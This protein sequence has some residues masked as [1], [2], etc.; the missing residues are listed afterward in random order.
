MKGPA[1]IARELPSLPLAVA[2]AVTLLALCASLA[3]HLPSETRDRPAPCDAACRHR[4]LPAGLG[5]Y[6]V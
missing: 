2:I 4:S 1:R 5:H 6:A 3:G